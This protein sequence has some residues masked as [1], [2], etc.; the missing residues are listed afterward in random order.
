MIHQ[1][2]KNEKSKKDGEKQAK[3]PNKIKQMSAD[4][5]FDHFS[6]VPKQGLLEDEAKKAVDFERNN[7]FNRRKS[8]KRY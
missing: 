1:K 2:P 3:N 5:V 7:N 6:S 4:D 8:S